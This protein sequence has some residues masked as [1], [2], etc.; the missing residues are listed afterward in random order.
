MSHNN[1]DYLLHVL[2]KIVEARDFYFSLFDRPLCSH[3]VLIVWWWISN[4]RKESIETLHSVLLF[5]LSY[6]LVS[7]VFSSLL[8]RLLSPVSSS[9]ISPYTAAAVALSITRY[10]PSFS[11]HLFSTHVPGIR[12]V[13]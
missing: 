6:Y 7:H 13:S 1:K 10:R 2:A 5:Y 11:C 8:R 12:N 3:S 9:P 4:H